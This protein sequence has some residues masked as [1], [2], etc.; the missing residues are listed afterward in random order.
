M[1]PFA[2]TAVTMT[3]AA[4]ALL[5][6]LA[7]AAQ[8]MGYAD[9]DTPGEAVG[10]MKSTIVMAAKMREL[11]GAR[12]PSRVE[13][14]EANLGR[15]RSREQS[16]I[17]KAEFHWSR[18]VQKQPKLVETL[19]YAETAVARNFETLLSAPG[20]AGDQVASQYCRQH[21]ADLSSGIWRTRTPRAYAYLDHAP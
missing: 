21:F 13:E 20:D 2:T 19:G 6:P 15:W 8:S 10:M 5:L 9:A 16:V 18:M 3:M 7:A 14:M 17:A 1:R 11:C 12:F 4:A